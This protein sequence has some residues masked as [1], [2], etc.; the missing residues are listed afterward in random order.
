M[1]TTVLACEGRD[2]LAAAALDRLSPA[3]SPGARRNSRLVSGALAPKLADHL[4]RFAFR[5]CF[6]AKE[7]FGRRMAEIPITLVTH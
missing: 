6:T 4:R 1:K 7:R 2:S 5:D 3:M